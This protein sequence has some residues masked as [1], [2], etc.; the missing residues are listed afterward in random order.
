MLF[1]DSSSALLCGH[2]AVCHAK[3]HVQVTINSCPTHLRMIV[4]YRADGKVSGQLHIS[5]QVFTVRPLQLHQAQHSVRDMR[6]QT[7]LDGDRECIIA[8]YGLTQDACIVH[9]DSAAIGASDLGCSTQGVV[10]PGER[11]EGPHTDPPPAQLLCC[12]THEPTNVRPCT[13]THVSCS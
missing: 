10:V 1:S 2:A 12:I 7:A 9:R 11:V 3:Q 8:V 4:A 5:E 6:G 13:S